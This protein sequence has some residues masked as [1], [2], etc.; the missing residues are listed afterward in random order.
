[1]KPELMKIIAKALGYLS[2]KSGCKLAY[3]G[4]YCTCGVDCFIKQIEALEKDE[5]N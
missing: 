2:H 4:D 1:M 5:T 3:G